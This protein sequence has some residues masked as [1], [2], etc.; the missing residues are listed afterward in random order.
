[1]K[2]NT[3]TK[4]LL[5]I[6]CYI[7]FFSFTAEAYARYYL[8]YSSSCSFNCYNHHPRWHHYRHMTHH[9]HYRKHN[10]YSIVVYSPVVINSCAYPCGNCCNSC[11]CFSEGYL[12]HSPTP[13]EDC[14][15]ANNYASYEPYMTHDSDE[16]SNTSFLENTNY[17]ESS[18]TTSGW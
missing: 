7:L 17:D 12:V 16:D 5:I 18:D 15:F 6:S 4:L 11:H 13:Y 10:S 9:Y 2:T 8:V 1:M 14:M 3:I